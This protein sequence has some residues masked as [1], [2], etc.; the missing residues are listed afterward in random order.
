MKHQQ[1]SH[2]NHYVP[3]FLMKPWAS[4]DGNL[5]AYWWNTRKGRLEC[6]KKGTKAF[7]FEIDALTLEEHK[8]GPDALERGFFAEVDADGSVARELIL[9][10]GPESLSNDTKCDFARLLLSLEA[11][12]P[13]VARRL[14]EES[15][16]EMANILDKDPI[17]LCAMET[18]QMSLSPSAFMPLPCTIS[19]H[20]FIRLVDNPKM[21]GRLINAHW[22][23][24]RLGPRDGTLI[25]SDR[26]LVRVLGYDNPKA[27][28]FL[29][30][31]PKAVFYAT[32]SPIDFAGLTP[33][34]LAKCLNADS[35]R[36]A[37]K[38]VFGVDDSHKRLLE[39]H[40]PPRHG[41]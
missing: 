2:K 5:N 38:Y 23:V 13:E 15:P 11:R 7:C 14:R 25:L 36:Q 16:Q 37:Q 17:L 19:E 1:V 33:R 9:R 34:R 40:L 8:E 30:L 22:Q 32:Y 39:K 3:R 18:E 27:A 24:V 31:S 41:A 29:P 20:M 12:R 28:W 21:G 35:V 6:N 26:P 4:E 10:E